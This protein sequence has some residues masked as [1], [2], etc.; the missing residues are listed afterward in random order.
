MNGMPGSLNP[1]WRGGSIR[2]TCEYCGTG[3]CVIPS[4]AAIARCCT[5]TCWNAIQNAR[6]LNPPNPNRGSRGPQSPD[7]LQARFLTHFAI[8]AGCWLWSG[9]INEHGYGVLCLHKQFWLAHR[10]AYTHHRGNIPDGLCVLHHC[11]VRNC[12]NPAHLFLGT[13]ADNVADMDAKGRRVVP[14][15]PGGENH[16]LS[17]LTAAAVAEI[18]ERY[19]PRS[20]TLAQLGREFGVS[21]TTVFHVIKGRKYR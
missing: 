12:V 19:V 13:Q 21:E 7:N 15:V 2:K 5:L 9:R 1:N 10:F 16:P 8:S 4:R 14:Q 6:R 17:K 20:V 3:F 11:D 18:R